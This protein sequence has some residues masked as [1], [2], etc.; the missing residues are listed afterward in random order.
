[1]AG[2]L[3][4]CTGPSEEKIK[5]VSDACEKFISKQMEA[6]EWSSDIETYVFETWVKNGNI[7]ASGWI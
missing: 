4:G 2:F 1:M 5:I 3:T 7:V 6:S